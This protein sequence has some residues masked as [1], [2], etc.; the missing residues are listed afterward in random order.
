MMYDGTRLGG[1]PIFPMWYRWG[2][3]W[4][5]GR[6]YQVLTAEERADSEERLREYF[7]AHPE[8]HCTKR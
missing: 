8:G 5:Y 2:Y 1:S 6:G 4:P 7:R 3:G